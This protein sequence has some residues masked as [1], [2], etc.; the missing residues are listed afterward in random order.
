MQIKKG[1]AVKSVGIVKVNLVEFLDKS[2]G[3][4]KNGQRQSIPLQKC[5]DKNA[6]V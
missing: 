6:L 1:E 2:S 3:E 5:P 4:S